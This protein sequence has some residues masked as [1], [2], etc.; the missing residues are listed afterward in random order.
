MIESH[1]EVLNKLKSHTKEKL[2]KKN[3]ENKVNLICRMAGNMYKLGNGYD[4]ENV[5]CRAIDIYKEVVKQL[6]ESPRESE[7]LIK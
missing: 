2:Q 7:E 6:E 3:Y 4:A 5:V 1:E